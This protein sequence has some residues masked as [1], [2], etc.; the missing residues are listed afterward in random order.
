MP[1]VNLRILSSSPQKETLYPLAVTSHFTPMPPS[2]KQPLV[3][4]LFFLINLLLISMIG[5]L[6]WSFNLNGFVQYLVFHDWLPK[7]GFVLCG[8][9]IFF[10]SWELT[11]TAVKGSRW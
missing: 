6:V 1:T 10:S 5:Y 8:V 11:V 7:Y 4:L 3:N 2:P 9:R